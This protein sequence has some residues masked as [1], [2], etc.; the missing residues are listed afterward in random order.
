MVMEFMEWVLGVAGNG[1]YGM[2]VRWLVMEDM[3]WVLGGW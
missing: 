2:G 1:G 3:E